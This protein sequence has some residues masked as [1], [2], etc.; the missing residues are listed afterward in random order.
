MRRGAGCVGCGAVA[1]Q[2]A[3]DASATSP[4]VPKCA[5]LSP[6][7]ARQSKDCLRVRVR[8]HASLRLRLARLAAAASPAQPIRS[9]LSF[10]VGGLCGSLGSRSRIRRKTR[11]P[12]ANAA[13]MAWSEYLPSPCNAASRRLPRPAVCRSLRLAPSHRRPLRTFEAQVGSRVPRDRC[14]Q[15]PRSRGTRDPTGCQ[16]LREALMWLKSRCKRD[17]CAGMKA[18]IN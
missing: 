18:G 7:T 3:G 5:W 14:T 1:C 15:P 9:A 8:R 12:F 17:A 2:Y 6:R 4:A 10:V 13:C 11:H 16:L